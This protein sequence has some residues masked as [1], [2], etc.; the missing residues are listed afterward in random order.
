MSLPRILR[1]IHGCSAIVHAMCIPIAVVLYLYVPDA[2]AA[3]SI[4]YLVILSQVT[5]LSTDLDGW[6]TARTAIR[7]DPED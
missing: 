4:L 2:W 6:L 7:A 3:I 1:T 5:A